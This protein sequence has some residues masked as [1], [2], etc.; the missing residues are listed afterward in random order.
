MADGKPAAISI[1]DLKPVHGILLGLVLGAALVAAM[2][3]LVKV[4]LSNQRVQVARDM[5]AEEKE[6]KD[7]QALVD[8]LPKYMKEHAELAAA[9]TVLV[10][11]KLAPDDNTVRWGNTL[12]DNLVQTRE[13]RL[14]QFSPAG[15][16]SLNTTI[17]DKKGTKPVFSPFEEFRVEM[18]LEG[19]YHQIGRF[20]A[21]IEAEL[22]CTRI[23]SL[24]LKPK[25][26]NFKEGLKIS[27]KLGFLT[28]SGRGFPRAQRPVFETTTGENPS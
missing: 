22:P 20:L 15:M 19:S 13:M 21:S 28:F 17:K 11:G 3:F 6:L 9:L 27:L 5:V 8:A 1:S 4:P 7:N 10:S 14:G 18:D 23:D 16:G 2:H 24:T 25:G 26:K 12:V